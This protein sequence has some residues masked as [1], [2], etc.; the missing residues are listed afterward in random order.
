MAGGGWKPVEAMARPRA[1]L[2]QRLA[3]GAA[4]V[5]VLLVLQAAFAGLTGDYGPALSIALASLAGP[6]VG[7][8]G[9]AFVRA[10]RLRRTEEP[11]AESVLLP[12]N[13]CDPRNFY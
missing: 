6:S 9:Y 4:V 2:W 1:R 12:N 8:S 7:F 3:W 11:I 10:R 5:A 13:D